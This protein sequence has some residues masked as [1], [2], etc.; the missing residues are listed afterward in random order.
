VREQQINML[1]E[2]FDEMSQADREMLV[3]LAQRRAAAQKSRKPNL[4]LVVDRAMGRRTELL[5]SDG[6]GVE[7]KRASSGGGFFK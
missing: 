2:A 3:A 6:C 5:L 7:D 1:V 4:R